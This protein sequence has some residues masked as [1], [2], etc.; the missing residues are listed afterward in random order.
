MHFFKSDPVQE[1]NRKKRQ[2][3]TNDKRQPNTQPTSTADHLQKVMFK[4]LCWT[5]M[6][7]FIWKNCQN[8]QFS[9]ELKMSHFDYSKRCASSVWTEWHFWLGYVLTVI[10]VKQ[11]GMKRKLWPK[12]KDRC[13]G[14]NVERVPWI[15]GPDRRAGAVY[16]RNASRRT[17]QTVLFALVLVHYQQYFTRNFLL[18][19]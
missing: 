19:L 9:E 6:G 16:Q 15:A 18:L 10:C 12:H 1:S 11:T 17:V 4:Y 14:W 7:E 8:Q 13:V 2:Q 3:N 5:F